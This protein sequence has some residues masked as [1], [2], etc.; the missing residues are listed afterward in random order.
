MRKKFCSR[1]DLETGTRTSY[2]IHTELFFK[3]YDQLIPVQSNDT[4]VQAQEKNFDG[5]SA[6]VSGVIVDRNGKVLIMNKPNIIGNGYY[7]QQGSIKKSG[8]LHVVKQNGQYHYYL[9]STE[10]LLSQQDR[11]QTMNKSLSNYNGKSVTVY[12]Y[13]GLVFAHPAGG[14]GLYQPDG[15]TLPA[16]HVTEIHSSIVNYTQN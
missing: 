13:Q 1:S 8:I 7:N 9:G 14:N 6:E 5:V 2:S 15:S 16:I 11:F 4:S 10:L 3:Y 12:G